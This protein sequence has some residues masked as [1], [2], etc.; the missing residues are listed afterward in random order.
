[1]TRLLVADGD[2]TTR[3]RVRMALRAASDVRMVGEAV[4]AETTIRLAHELRPSI[5]V[6]DLSLPG[7]PGLRLIRALSLVLPELRI[8]AFSLDARFQADALFAGA[9]AFVIR[10]A[11]EKE[12]VEHIR[13]LASE[14]REGTAGLRV[15]TQRLGEYLLAHGVINKTQLDAALAWQHELQTRGR[16]QRLGEILLEIGAISA[17][18]LERALGEV[19]APPERRA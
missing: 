1:M 17:D 15:G 3:D 16:S 9:A 7:M 4:D 19:E 8:I 11:L 12:L 13:R 10:D 5:L 14:T 18:A 6:L 2:G